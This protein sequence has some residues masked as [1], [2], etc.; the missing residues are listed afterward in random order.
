MRATWTEPDGI[1]V[2]DYNW[3]IGCRYCMAACPYRSRSFNW[4]DP[5]I[6]KEEI[7]LETYYLGNRP[8]M[9]NV[10]EKCHF[11]I[12]RVRQRK[13]PVCVEVCPVGA[14]NFRNLLY[15]ESEI[16][17]AMETKRVFRLKEELHTEPLFFSFSMVKV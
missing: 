11:Y 15:P 4:S 1:V 17:L 16:R 3:Y 12:L 2:I 8:K 13:Y 7:N 14:R 6:P 9:R 10:V 5:Q